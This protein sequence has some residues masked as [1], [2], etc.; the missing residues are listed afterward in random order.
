MGETN[1]PQGR[2][3]AGTII[4]Y[5]ISGFVV[6]IFISGITLFTQE[7]LSNKRVSREHN[8]I[9][10]NSNL[11]QNGKQQ[12]DTESGIDN[13]RENEVENK[14]LIITAHQFPDGDMKH[15]ERTIDIKLGL[16]TDQE[17]NTGYAVRVPVELREKDIG[18]PFWKYS[19]R[20]TTDENGNLVF[21]VKSSVYLLYI[22]ETS[23]YPEYVNRY[24][25][26]GFANPVRIAVD[27]DNEKVDV[28]AL[29]K[30]KTI[31]KL[32]GKVEDALTGKDVKTGL[33][34]IKLQKNDYDKIKLPL[35]DDGSFVVELP[36]MPKQIYVTT[37]GIDG[38]EPISKYLNVN[39]G[40]IQT[41]KLQPI[42]KIVCKIEDKGFNHDAY[43]IKPIL[44]NQDKR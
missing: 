42:G 18:T 30:Q 7:L 26:C 27:V 8:N 24:M 21:T 44:Q 15:E 9:S 29:V 19:G 12:V 23:I 38:Y 22:G 2:S 34:I 13:I 25:P 5:L 14:A 37:V 36:E 11:S 35:L 40:H 33:V 41:I 39:D 6:G 32:D 3:T 1:V 4:I 17:V 31:V 10:G 20:G 28:S 16:C 43:V